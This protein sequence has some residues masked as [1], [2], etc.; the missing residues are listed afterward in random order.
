MKSLSLLSLVLA[1]ALTGCDAGIAGS[2]GSAPA[3]SA[4]PAVSKCSKSGGTDS[5]PT[6]AA[7]A[8]TETPASVTSCPNG[9]CDEPGDCGLEQCEGEKTEC[10]EMKQKCDGSVKKQCDSAPTAPKVGN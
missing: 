2:S 8:A 1:A 5:C 10:D 3:G 4:A 9:K 7:A 6:S